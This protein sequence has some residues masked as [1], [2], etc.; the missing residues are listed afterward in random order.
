MRGTI[1]L[2]TAR[3]CLALRPVMDSVLRAALSAQQ[4]GRDT[5]GIDR[6]ELRR[7][8]RRCSP[9]SRMTRAELGR[10]P[11]RALACH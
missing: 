6:D 8:P 4:F 2:V 9:T 5:A 3:D 7:P 1:H 11:R 10:G